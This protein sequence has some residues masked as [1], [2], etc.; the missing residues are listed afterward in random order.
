M[1]IEIRKEAN[2]L[3]KIFEQRIEAMDKRAMEIVQSCPI[4]S[5][6]YRAFLEVKCVGQQTAITLL[7]EVPELGTMNRNQAA[8]LV[9]VGLDN[10]TK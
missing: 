9:G 2:L 3:M 5:A 4:L 1:A 8:A 7:G 6:K 10:V